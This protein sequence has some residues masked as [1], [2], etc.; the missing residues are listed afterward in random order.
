MVLEL[1]DLFPWALS[2]E[3]RS[4]SHILGELDSKSKDSSPQVH[5]AFEVFT[6]HPISR[7][8]KQLTFPHLILPTRI[9]YEFCQS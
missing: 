4:H 5:L 6:L 2:E 7:I 9:S 3:H 8:E 1:Y